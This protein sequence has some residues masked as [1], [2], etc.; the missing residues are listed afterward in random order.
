MV[1]QK[2]NGSTG[3]IGMAPLITAVIALIIGVTVSQS[4]ADRDENKMPFKDAEFFIE[5]NSSAGDTGV[6][7]FLDDD[8]WRKITISDPNDRTIFMVKGETTLGRQGLT[9]LF[10]ESVEPELVA[11]PI[12]IF[13][14]RFPEGDYE[15]KG[16]RND[17]IKLE[18][19]AEFT[20][21]IPCG[22]VVSPE[23][24]EILDPSLEVIIS[25]GVVTEVVDPAATDAAEETVCTDPDELEQELFIESYQVIVEAP[26]GNLIVDLSDKAMELTVPSEIIE[27]NTLYKFEVLAKE[28][29]GNQT[30]TESFFCTGP[31]LSEEDCEVLAEDL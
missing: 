17:G 7:V 4:W 29:S 1:R 11:L 10:F 2:M 6:Q 30:I 3:Y 19:D 15:F 23:E 9:E 28:E 16:L 20:H 8:N 25:W 27:E 26:D 12:E 21:V 14:D 18:S 24:S 31:D 13:L 5:Y 22:P